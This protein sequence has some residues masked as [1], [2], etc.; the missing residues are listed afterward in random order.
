MY[1]ADNRDALPMVFHGGYVPSPGSPGR[2]WV[3]GWLSWDTSSDNTNAIYLTDPGYGSLGLYLAGD[4]RV[5]KCPADVYL[6]LPQRAMGWEQRVRSVSANLYVGKGNAWS[7]GPGWS[8]GGPYNLSIYKGAPNAADLV[9]PG[10]ARTWVY[11]DEHPD[12]M[13]D[14]GLWAPDHKTNMPDVPA[15]YH[16]G[17][18][19]VAMADGHCEIHRWAG[20]AMNKP[21]RLSGLAGVAYTGM[22]NYAAVAGD[23]DLFWLSYG[24][25][26][27][28]TRTVAD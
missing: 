28:T 8:P 20:V 23:P 18:A 2:P 27:R 7:F 26:R 25:P 12:S 4:K 9:I 6:S 24:S 3:T 5:Y 21:R 13:N 14:G 17:A 19:G 1:S 10:P 22:N 15:T 16:D 11:M